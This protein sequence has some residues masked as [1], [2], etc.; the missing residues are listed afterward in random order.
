V[1]QHRH[2]DDD[3]LLRHP[4]DLVQPRLEIQAPGGVVEPGHH[5]LEGV[6]RGEEMVLVRPH[7]VLTGTEVGRGHVISRVRYRRSAGVT[8]ASRATAR[9]SPPLSH[10]RSSTATSGSGASAGQRS[11]SFTASFSVMTTW[12]ARRAAWASQAISSWRYA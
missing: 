2:R 1:P 3:L 9:A 4:Q 12:S 6:L 8:T 10:V 5:F 7:D 11:R